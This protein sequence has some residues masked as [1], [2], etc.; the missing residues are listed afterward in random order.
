MDR[1]HGIKIN[2]GLYGLLCRE[3][4]TA[5]EISDSPVIRMYN[6]ANC[7]MCCAHSQM[8]TTTLNARTKKKCK[9]CNAFE[10]EKTHA[11]S[12]SGD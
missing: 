12:R 5:I 6:C 9:I 1:G 8:H 3:R 10:R 2:D 7:I 11:R 4:K